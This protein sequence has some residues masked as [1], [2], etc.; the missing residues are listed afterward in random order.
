[1]CCGLPKPTL[2]IMPNNDFQPFDRVAFLEHCRLQRSLDAGWRL[3]LF[4]VSYLGG[5]LLFALPIRSIEEQPAL[6][7]FWFPAFFGYLIVFP[8]IM[9]RCLVPRQHRGQRKHFRKCPCCGGSTQM[10]N[11][12]VIV[13]TGRCGLCGEV[14]LAGAA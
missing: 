12:L 9:Q 4:M 1:M 7:W 2:T 8:W 13:A 10:G 5:M 3:G 11:A 14:I 6:A